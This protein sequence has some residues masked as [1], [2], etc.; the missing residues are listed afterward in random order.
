MSLSQAFDIFP[1][2]T[3]EML[4]EFSGEKCLAVI[5]A[6][7]RDLI[8]RHGFSF[9]KLFGQIHSRLDDKLHRGTG[10]RILKGFGKSPDIYSHHLQILRGPVNQNWGPVFFSKLPS[11]DQQLTTFYDF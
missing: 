6:G 3:A 2:G 10:N 1:R 4:F 5:T 7:L 9:Q 8:N 11:I